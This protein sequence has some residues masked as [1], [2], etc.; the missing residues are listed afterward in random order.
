MHH[1]FIDQTPVDDNI[2]LEGEDYNHIVNALRKKIR[3][4]ISL[5]PVKSSE[6]YFC[7]IIEILKK[8]VVVKILSKE[9]QPQQKLPKITIAQ[10]LPKGQKMEEIIQKC[11]ELGAYDFLPLVTRRTVP[12]ISLKIAKKIERWQKIAKEAAIQSESYFVPMVYNPIDLADIMQIIKQEQYN[13]VFCLKERAQKPIKDL[14]NLQTDRKLMFIIGPE[15]G[16]SEEEDRFFQQIG[17]EQVNISDK[18]LRTE[19]AGPAIMAIM[20]YIYS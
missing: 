14:I 10:S 5:I 13:K 4:N 15:G 12:D 18:I 11:T 16:F 20:G 6:L 17:I 19:T 7:E 8:Q 2:V 1:F 3:D 9:P